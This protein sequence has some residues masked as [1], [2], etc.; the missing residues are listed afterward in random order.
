M[1]RFF[2][3]GGPNTPNLTDPQFLADNHRIVFLSEQSGFRHLHVLD[4]TYQSVRQLT[5]GNFE[6]Y[7][8]RISDDHE[9]LFVT[10]SQQSPV[11]QMVYRVDLETGE[12]SPISDVIGNYSSVA[13]SNDG[14]RALA[15]MVTFGTPKEL[16]RI[17]VDQSEK[18]KTLTD[19]HPEKT[20]KLV[21]SKPEFFTFK[22][23]HGHLL[24]GQVFKPEGWKESDKRPCLIY[25]YG[26]P[27][28]SDHMVN[29]GS[30]S[31]DSY[32]FAHYM[33]QK[34]GY[35]TVTIDPRGQ[36]GYG[37]MFEKANYEQVGKPQ[38]ED[39]VDG[40]K[41]LV[42]NYGVDEKKIG[43]HG[44]SFGGFQT[45]MCLYSEPDVFAAG[46]A[47]AGPTEWENYNKWY[48]R[49]TIGPT[50]EGQTDQKKY[51]LIPLAKNLKSQLLLVH[52]MSDSNVLFQDTVKVYQALLK[53]DKETLV[54]LFLDPSGGHGLGGD[55]KAIHK[56]RKYESFLMRVLGT[57]NDE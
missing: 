44:W 41:Y 35:V 53:A 54:E 2:H 34:H 52:G 50:R 15:N 45:Q 13:V 5:Q 46:I 19:S 42:E 3:F 4:P 26:G 40:A 49:A 37:G 28:G 14:S 56:Y 9:T 32:F 17:D 38:A 27:L 11:R 7:F 51:S 22:N 25:V 29:D 30:Y 55:I 12:M 23:R 39:L 36:S 48:S 18:T 31:R 20:K 10:S 6:V 33:A 24:Q 8:N 57:A 16:V 1:Y 47:G 43:L 21:E